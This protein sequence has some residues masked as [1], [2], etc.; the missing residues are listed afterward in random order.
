MGVFG[1][2]HLPI[3]VVSATVSVYLPAKLSPDYL[4]IN[5]LVRGSGI[6]SKDNFS[7]ARTAKQLNINK[8]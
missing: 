8:Q 3:S 1:L 7:R 4:S 2:Q 6:R 5:A